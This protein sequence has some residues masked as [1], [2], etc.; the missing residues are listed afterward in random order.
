MGIR[1]AFAESTV[2]PVMDVGIHRESTAAHSTGTAAAVSPHAKVPIVDPLRVEELVASVREWFLDSSDYEATEVQ[3]LMTE[4]LRHSDHLY[5]VESAVAWAEG[6]AWPVEVLLK[7]ARLLSE[8]GQDSA[9]MVQTRQQL[10]GP[11]R[12]SSARVLGLH[13]DN[14]EIPLMLRIASGMTVPLPSDFVPNGVGPPGRLSKMYEAAAPAVDRMLF[15]LHTQGL[16]FVLA[17]EEARKIKNLH[18]AKASWT[19]K[20]DKACGRGLSDMTNCSGMS[21]NTEETKLKAEELWGTIHHPTITELVRLIWSFWERCQ[22]EEAEVSWDDLV[23]WKMDLRGAYT[24]LSVHPESAA[25][26]ALELRDGLTFIPF[27]GVFG[28]TVI[29][30][31]FQVVTRAIK[32]EI[33]SVVKGFIEMYVDD[34]FG[35]VLR[36]DLGHDLRVARGVCTNLLGPDAVADSKTDSGRLL[37]ML[38]WHIN[39]DAGFLSIARKNLL[40]AFHGFCHVKTDEKVRIKEMQKLASLSSRYALVCPAM[41][42]FTAALNRMIMGFSGQHVQILLSPEAKL[43]ILMWRAML[44]LMAGHESRYARSLGTFRPEAVSWGIQ[45]DASLSGAGGLCYE[46]TPNGAR[47]FVG[48]FA[49]DLTPMGFGI[50]SS[51]Q[52]VSEFLGLIMGLVALALLGVRNVS[53]EIEGDSKTALSWAHTHCFRSRNATRASVVF[54]LVC[55][56]FG[57][58][59]S[60]SSHISG[61]ENWRADILSRMVETESVEQALERI[62]HPGLPVIRLSDNQHAKDLLE[63]CEPDRDDKVMGVKEFTPVWAKIRKALRMLEGTKSAGG[64][65]VETSGRQEANS[66]AN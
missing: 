53:L 60:E 6:F 18:V 44:F 62:G 36:R 55:L 15:E 23:I 7:D 47:L 11:S 61:E 46:R 13:P 4:A 35:I 52:N 27:C 43:S 40:N 58:T 45:T 34:I 21:L 3:D 1:A 54:T 25:L 63:C 59:I 12:L 17:T 29:P 2:M 30:F 56:A 10:L 41:A 32:W 50:D 48:G 38:G 16:G 39:L 33:R 9:R 66:Q 31:I 20:K 26:F 37:D 64:W 14:P 8:A 57:F 65:I 49:V 42:P 51:F 24:L 22:S 19:S 5:G 28:W